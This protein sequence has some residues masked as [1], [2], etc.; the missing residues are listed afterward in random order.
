[1]LLF[2]TGCGVELGDVKDPC[3]RLRPVHSSS[4]I[5]SSVTEMYVIDGKPVDDATVQNFLWGDPVTHGEA[6]RSRAWWVAAL[7]FIGVGIGTLSSSIALLATHDR[8]R[9]A[10]GST[11]LGVAL[12]T[13]AATTAALDEE[14]LHLA[15][16]VK[17]A[18]AE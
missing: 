17:A 9:Q 3:P 6:L 14:Q 7:G 13:P 15:R 18:C 12:A 1:M 2:V 4:R 10:T 11:L 16:A 5:F 8:A